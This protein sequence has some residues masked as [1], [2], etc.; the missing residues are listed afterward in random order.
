MICVVIF[1]IAISMIFYEYSRPGRQWPKVRNWWLRAILFN[2]LQV[3]T[4]YLAGVSWDRWMLNWKHDG[5]IDVNSFWG[6]ILGYLVIT[7]V[8]YWWH[9]WR[10]LSDFLWRWLHQ[11]HHSPQRLEIA[12][13]FYKHPFELIAD[14]IICSV[15]LFPCLGLTAEAG[16]NAVLLSGLAELFYHWNIKTPYWVGFIFQRPESHCIHHQSGLHAYNYSDLPLW[17]MLFGTFRN[18]KNWNQKCGLG[19]SEHCLTELLMGQDL[20]AKTRIKK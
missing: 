7:L 11:V 20:S 19:E 14:S 6:G 16:A 9:R 3:G 17:D 18:P 8:F 5:L 4:V 13:A 12:T 15:I 10:H 2:S 1:I